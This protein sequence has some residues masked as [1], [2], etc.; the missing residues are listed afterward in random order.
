MRTR[1]AQQLL[2]NFITS[3]L[4]VTDTEM[5]IWG[6]GITQQVD[7][8]ASTLD[9]GYRGY[10]ADIRCNGATVVGVGA[11]AGAA[12]PGEHRARAC[13][14]SRSTPSSAAQS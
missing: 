10:E 12:Q 8:A 7:A 11:C 9:L 3:Q 2:L 4:I 1:F 5:T 6:I 14:P 13:R